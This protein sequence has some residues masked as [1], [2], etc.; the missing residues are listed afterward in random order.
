MHNHRHL[1][2][3]FRISY[4][5]RGLVQIAQLRDTA[6]AVKTKV[7]LERNKSGIKGTRF[8]RFDIPGADNP[9]NRKLGT[10]ITSGALEVVR[11][12]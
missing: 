10:P 2:T 5:V 4:R 6:Q 9:A 8:D 3:L 7:L 1:K 11:Q 12:Y